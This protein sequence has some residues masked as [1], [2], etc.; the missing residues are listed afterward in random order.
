MMEAFDLA[1]ELWWSNAETAT[2][3]YPA[4][5]AEYRLANPVPHLSDFMKASF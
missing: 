1:T 5:L 2:S 4:E 3:L